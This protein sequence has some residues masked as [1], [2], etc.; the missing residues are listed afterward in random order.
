[1]LLLA[2]SVQRALMED[3]MRREEKRRVFVPVES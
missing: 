2:I 3:G 1:M